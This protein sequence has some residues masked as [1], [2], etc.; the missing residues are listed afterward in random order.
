MQITM[1]ITRFEDRK[2]QWDSGHVSSVNSLEEFNQQQFW[3]REVCSSRSA[4]CRD[5]TA[6]HPPAT[7]GSAEPPWIPW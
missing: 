6:I 1:A 7:L 3:T 5:L 4:A 2:E